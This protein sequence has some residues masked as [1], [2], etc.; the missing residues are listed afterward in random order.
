MIPEDV[1][2]TLVEARKYYSKRAGT[3][4][5]TLAMKG[6]NRSTVVTSR[7]GKRSVRRRTGKDILK[8]K[9]KALKN[10]FDYK[11]KR[12]KVTRARRLRARVLKA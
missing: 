1:R 6:K 9:M 5:R 2:A 4:R 10:K 3:L 11:R 7:N 8:N 12:K